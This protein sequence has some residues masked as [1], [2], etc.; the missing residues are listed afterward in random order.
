MNTILINEPSTCEVAPISLL[1]SANTNKHIGPQANQSHRQQWIWTVLPNWLTI[2]NH[3]HKK[4]LIVWPE[5][6]GKTHQP[7]FHLVNFGFRSTTF[8][9]LPNSLAVPTVGS[10]SLSYNFFPKP[11]ECSYQFSLIK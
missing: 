2:D 3:T 11:F 9:K 5:D 6:T 1:R 4:R 8:P 10:W 7:S